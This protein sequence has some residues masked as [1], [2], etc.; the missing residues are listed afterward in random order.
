M[1]IDNSPIFNAVPTATLRSR[2]ETSNFCVTILCLMFT[3][4]GFVKFLRDLIPVW[5]LDRNCS[6]ILCGTIFNP[7]HDHSPT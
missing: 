4:S 5:Q 2:S 7:E 6:K 3:M 1:M